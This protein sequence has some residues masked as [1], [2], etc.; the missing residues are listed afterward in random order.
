MADAP[1]L[2]PCPCCGSKAE[3]A[4]ATGRGHGYVYGL[5]YV[6]CAECGMRTPDFSDDYEVDEVRPKAAAIWNRRKPA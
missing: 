4:V 1:E 2:M 3:Y 5:H 6:S